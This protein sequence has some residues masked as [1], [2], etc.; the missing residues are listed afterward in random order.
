MNSGTRHADTQTT[1]K[2]TPGSLVLI[3]LIYWA[4]G[5]IGISFASAP[6]YASPIFPAAGLRPPP[7]CAHAAAPRRPSWLG[8]FALNV[9]LSLMQGH[10][11]MRSALAAAGIA[12]GTT[13][14]A[15]VAAWLVLRYAGDGWKRMEVERETLL[16]LALA[17]PVACGVSASFGIFTLISTGLLALG[18]AP[19][20]M[21]NWW[22]GDVLGVC[23]MLPLSLAI[24]F[25]HDA[26][27]RHRL[28]AQVL[29]MAVVLSLVA[30]TFYTVTRWERLQERERI[31]KHGVALAQL[32]QQRFI[33][34]QEALAALR[35]LVEVTPQ[36]TFAQFE[37][38]TRITLK[39]NPDI[40]ALSVN[41]YVT[42]GQRPLF[43]R[44]MR[45]VTAGFEIRERDAS[46][47]LIRA[48][49]RDDYV[50]VALIAPL[51][52][53]A[54]AIGYDINSDPVRADAIA[55]AR[56]S[57][58]PAITAPIQLVQEN[59]KRPGVLVLHP[60]YRIDDTAPDDHTPA[61]LLGFAVGV[62]K[63]DEMMDIAT[64]TVSIEGLNLR[65]EDQQASPE[66]ALL[67]QRGNPAGLDTSAQW[68]GQ[69]AVADR[70]WTLSVYP[71]EAYMQHQRHWLA[72]LIGTGGLALASLLQ[73]LLLSTTGR[74]AA[75]ERKVKLQTSE[76]EAKSLALEDRNARLDAL[77]TLSRM[78][79]WP[80]TPP[81]SCA[82]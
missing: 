81:A 58:S 5:A 70:T 52:G 57:A 23:I 30:G 32:I 71:T 9:S 21:L 73:V 8:S 16:C 68:Q 1:L 55:R 25:R 28:L 72:L 2:T 14:Q 46:R 15:L 49:E 53:N 64:R 44:G 59:K 19:Y 66:R 78:V 41:P 79:L 61:Q 69:V 54:A 48:H 40:F 77:F 36:M 7:C 18:D 4:L 31:E 34:H 29:P 6:G 39:D 60:A 3:G 22:L 13:L 38:F 63:V 45:K 12:T 80:S 47:Q 26:L 27:W 37:Y 62:I 11:G 35:R 20:A 65:L 76:I 24:A 56:E 42:R 51:P 75:V 50:A 74:T 10:W 82:L 67:Y 33:A 17:G 43:E